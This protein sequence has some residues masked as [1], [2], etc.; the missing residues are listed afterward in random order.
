M[1]RAA[2]IVSLAGCTGSAPT[3]SGSDDAPTTM[4][5]ATTSDGSDPSTTTEPQDDDSGGTADGGTSHTDDSSGSSGSS[6]SGG[7]ARSLQYFGFVGVSCMVDDPDDEQGPRNYVDEIA[8]FTNLAHLCPLDID[9]T[10]QLDE[11]HEAH[12]RAFV[13][14]TLVLFELVPGEA[15]V[16]SGSQLRLRPD[17]E[18]LFG[19]FVSENPRLDSEHVGAFYL[20]DE[21]IWNGTPPEEIEAAAVLVEAAFP[22]IPSM[23]IEAY[24]VVDQAVFP[25][26]VD[27]VGFD[28]YLVADP[29]SDPD[30][31]ADLETVRARATPDQQLVIILDAQWFS[32]HEMVP[33]TQEDMANVAWHTYELAASRDDVAAII[34]YTWPGGLDLPQQL[35]ARSLPPVVQQSYQD[36]GAQILEPR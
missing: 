5:A 26:A 27:W 16:G 24:P 33:L 7:P 2:L 32:L 20:I 36:I 23:V 9:I 35:G 8:G 15:P 12:L 17:A 10:P 6:G 11:L 22:S 4:D 3:G 19:A 25:D 31:L 18:Q 30:Y 21:P 29:S 1:R 28:R 13:D 14:L 34:G